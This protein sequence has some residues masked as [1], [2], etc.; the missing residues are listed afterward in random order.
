M[1]K[2]LL[3]GTVSQMSD[4]AHMS[5]VLHDMDPSNNLRGLIF[6]VSEFQNSNGR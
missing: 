1:Q 6:G 5:V 3:I 2:C 4:A